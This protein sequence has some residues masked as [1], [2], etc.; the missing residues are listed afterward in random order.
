MKD[1]DVQVAHSVFSWLPLTLSWVYNQVRFTPV[2]SIVLADRREP[3]EYEWSPIFTLASRR[4]R[5]AAPAAFRS[6]VR[7]VWPSFEAALK[8]SGSDLLHSHFGERGWFDSLLARRLGLRHVVTF[9]G[10]DL[11]FLPQAQRKWR[12]R[13][14]GLFEEADLLLCEGPI[15]ARTLMELGCDAEKIKVQRLGIDPTE[16]S[17]SPRTMPEDGTVRILIAAAFREKK[18]IPLALEAVAN[19]MEMNRRIQVTVIGDS[20]GDRREKAEKSRIQEVV[21]RRRM[22]P[23]VRF[24][25]FQP[26]ARL[27][28][29]AHAHHIFL[30]P[31]RTA[32]N[33]DTEGGAPVVLLEMAATGMPIVSTRHCDIPE[34][35]IDGKTGLSRRKPTSPI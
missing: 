3:S 5:L 35:V 27:I 29:E 15:M 22:G 19:V 4:E 30:S 31:S 32:A 13:Y 34:V 9:Y 28:E 33:G 1:G 18:G 20:L 17:M 24:L 16:F 2:P 26:H 10:Y 14:L 6:G 23:A 7:V 12:R 11:S 8:S 25:G 21:A